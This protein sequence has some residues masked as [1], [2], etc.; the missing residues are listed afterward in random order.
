MR[1]SHPGT[2]ARARRSVRA[3]LKPRRFLPRSRRAGD[4]APHLAVQGESYPVAQGN[5]TLRGGEACR[6]P[7]PTAQKNLDSK[8]KAT[9]PPLMAKPRT[10][11]SRSRLR[12]TPSRLRIKPSGVPTMRVNPPRVEMSDPQPGL[13]SHIAAS[14][15]RGATEKARPIRP[16]PAFGFVSDSAWIMGGSFIVSLSEL[17]LSGLAGRSQRPQVEPNVDGNFLAGHV[18]GYSP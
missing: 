11:A 16:N 4:R 13:H 6:Y 14:A 3:F 5:G 1:D 10:P 12:M 18:L 7:R 15:T 8:N 2:E 17:D 9:N